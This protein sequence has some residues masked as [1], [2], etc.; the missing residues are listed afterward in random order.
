VYLK[1]VVGRSAK[2]LVSIAATMGTVL[3]SISSDLV[4]GISNISQLC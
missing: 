3:I 4:S 2:P 1:F